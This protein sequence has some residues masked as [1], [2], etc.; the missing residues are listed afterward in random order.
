MPL[1]NA[2]KRITE[3]EARR[4][5][6]VTDPR[7][8]DNPI[9][10][11]TQYFLTYTGYSES[12]ILGRNC[13]FLQGPDTDPDDIAAIRQAVDACRGLTIDILNYR[14]DGTPFW[15]RLRMRVT[16]KDGEPD[17]FI[18]VQNP[19]PADEV[20]RGPVWEVLRD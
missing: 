9:I 17:S 15:N 18:G 16:F 4:C 10:Y 6:V 14:K 5:C 1:T 12:E 20:R 19:I 3:D 7:R 2:Y 13:R 11:A 8:D